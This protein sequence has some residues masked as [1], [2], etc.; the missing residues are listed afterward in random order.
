V[1]FLIS[2]YSGT[3]EQLPLKQIF[4]YMG[5]NR[6]PEDGELTDLVQRTLP[7][8]LGDVRC[9]CCYMTVPVD[10]LG[11]FVDLS[12]MSAESAHLAR[13]L[14]G[15]EEA[16]LFVATLGIEVEQQRK[17]AA[18][19]STAKAL[20]LDAMGSAAIEQFCNDFSG[21]IDSNY[22]TH[23]LRPR[24][25]PGYGD[26]SLDVQRDMLN[27]LDAQRKIG[28]SVTEG[29]LM[30]PQKSVSAVIGLSKT[31]CGHRVPDCDNCVEMMCEFRR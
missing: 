5:M 10:I 30:I 31:G 21:V 28:V 11:D 8:F 26:L 20:V 1:S 14:R 2:T 4:R 24:F 15:C 7:E 27:V 22:S 9:K 13:N 25:S 18:I 17:R 3:L 12:V 19:S 16:V 6:I 29:G 23:R